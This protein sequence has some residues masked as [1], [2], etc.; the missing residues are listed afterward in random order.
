ME[1]AFPAVADPSEARRRIDEVLEWTARSLADEFREVNGG[2]VVRSRSLPLVH[3][4]NRL[5][6]KQP[7]DPKEVLR[8]AD[9]HAADLA[10]RHIEV[11][12]AQTAA[13]LQH[14]LF[15]SGPGWRLDR[16]VF[17]VLD[18][19][20]ASARAGVGAD[21]DGEGT[22]VL[23]APVRLDD[24][25]ADRLMRQWFAEEHL[26]SDPDVVDQVSEYSL[27]EGGLWKEQVLGVREEGQAV[28][29]TK[30]RARG[31]VG[32]VED[33]YTAP[34]AR[35]KGYARLLVGHAADAAR[36]AGR[37]L[38]F[39]IADDNDWPKRLYA[40]LG[41]RPVGLTWTFHRDLGR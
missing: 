6:V 12:D 32:W 28:A 23:T 25:E 8:L 26:D 37:D 38:T 34:A 1:P 39:I 22:A 41:F 15:S 17:M 29:L 19:P 27:R 2:W 18:A 33:V 13:S 4:L 30:S 31:S 9:E 36:V 20:T 40:D 5:Q 35:R 21:P 16:E 24:D 11:D 10:Y 7:V 14:S 3:S